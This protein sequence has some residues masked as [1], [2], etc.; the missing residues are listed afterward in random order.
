LADDNVSV[1][2]EQVED[3]SDETS[4]LSV[5]DSLESRDRV[6]LWTEFIEQLVRDMKALKRDS[7][8][9]TLR[10]GI[11]TVGSIIIT[12]GYAGVGTDS[13][14][15]AASFASHVGAVFFLTQMM[16]IAMHSILVDFVNQNPIFIREIT[17]DHY[18]MITCK[19]TRRFPIACIINCTLLTSIFLHLLID[20]TTKLVMEAWTGFVQV[21]ILMVITYWS[22]DLSGRFLYLLAVLFLYAIV[23]SSLGVLL[24]SATKV[25]MH[26][27]GE[28]LQQIEC[29]VSAC[30]PPCLIFI[31]YQSRIQEVPRSL[32]PSSSFHKFFCVDSSSPSTTCRAGLRGHIGSCR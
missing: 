28:G 16:L 10:F 13:L 7:E 19:S 9:M 26:P 21:L 6:S 29:A 30:L 18:R 8:S 1:D 32:F 22:L 23:G 15:S 31:S 27:T 24:A 2:V 3:I 25:I 20:A 5:F 17:T 11:T 4:E 12:F 14:D